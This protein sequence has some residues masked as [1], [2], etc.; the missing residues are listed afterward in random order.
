MHIYGALLL[1][2]SWERERERERE[3]EKENERKASIQVLDPYNLIIYLPKIKDLSVLE[4]L[5]SAERPEKK[6]LMWP[7]KSKERNHT[8]ANRLFL[9]GKK[10][11]EWV[12]GERKDNA[13]AEKMWR[14]EKE[15]EKQEI[16]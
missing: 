8:W 4:K 10:D 3:R 7:C 5:L 15:T 16:L 6:N 1:H 12:E 13:N 9:V 11:K 2:C 14:G